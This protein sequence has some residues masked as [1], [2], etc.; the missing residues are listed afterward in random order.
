MLDIAKSWGA[1]WADFRA[2]EKDLKSWEV[3]QIKGTLTEKKLDRKLGKMY[4]YI[5]YKSVSCPEVNYLMFEPPNA[6]LKLEV[7]T[8]PANK[9]EGIK[10]KI[11]DSCEIL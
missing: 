5:M 1:E 4:T 10:Q 8:I 3:I 7:V 2:Y 9:L 11:G 6:K